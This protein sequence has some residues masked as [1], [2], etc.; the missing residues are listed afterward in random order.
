MPKSFENIAKDTLEKDKDFK[1]AVPE[2]L[3][4]SDWIRFML[5][6]KMFYK[7]QNKSSE[8]N[9]EYW[10]KDYDSWIDKADK[11]LLERF[12]LNWADIKFYD[13]L[14]IYKE[15]LGYVNMTSKNEPEWNEFIPYFSEH[16]GFQCDNPHLKQRKEFL[17]YV[18]NI[19]LVPQTLKYV[20]GLR[21][22]NMD[23]SFYAYFK[24]I[25]KTFITAEADVLKR[26]TEN[27]FS[28]KV[29]PGETITIISNKV[30]YNDIKDITVKLRE[31][32]NGQEHSIELSAKPGLTYTSL[33]KGGKNKP[34]TV[35]MIVK[36][37]P[38][39]TVPA[40]FLADCANLEKIVLS[41]KVIN[42][43]NNCFGGCNNIKKFSF[44]YDCKVQW[45]EM[46]PK[47]VDIDTRIPPSYV[48]IDNFT[49]YDGNDD[50]DTSF[51]LCRSLEAECKQSD[52][53]HNACDEEVVADS[54]V[55]TDNALIRDNIAQDNTVE[56]RSLD[57]ILKNS[58]SSEAFRIKGIELQIDDFM[59]ENLKCL[60]LM[61]DHLRAD[62]LYC[63]WF[64]WPGS[65]EEEKD[66]NGNYKIGDVVKHLKIIY[67]QE[68]GEK[69]DS[70]NWSTVKKNALNDYRKLSTILHAINKLP[71]DNLNIK[72]QRALKK[73]QY[74]YLKLLYQ[75]YSYESLSVIEN[76]AESKLR[77]SM[78]N[79]LYKEIYPLLKDE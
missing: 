69:S 75:G 78:K 60:A 22:D 14:S 4:P 10:I 58:T 13:L 64:G 23:N 32:F 16:I 38:N 28:F 40:N 63:S 76:M 2:N 29:E 47:A 20:L 53:I 55:S 33:S 61:P 56:S 74:G 57:V 46:D 51:N 31:S 5:N 79:W 44:K 73:T 35:K 49:D 48:Q 41:D 42:C 54:Q 19:L 71:A 12:L 52:D 67:P 59:Y 26:V 72:L 18:V 17:R 50:S 27:S 34:R 62:L 7:L 36:Q 65:T 30:L 11:D 39:N 8:Q 6:P 25:F 45:L 15:S 3:G 21:S 1:Q 37:F 43:S 68:A 70:F 9:Y 77:D 66:R 24:K